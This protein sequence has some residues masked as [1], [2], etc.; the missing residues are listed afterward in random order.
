MGERFAVVGSGGWGTALGL[1]A[2]DCGND[3]ML[4]SVFPEEIERIKKSRENS[5]LKGVAI[6]DDIKL[7]SDFSD[8]ASADVCIVSVPSVAVR[9]VAKSLNGVVRKDAIIVSVGKGLEE[10]SLKRL[11]Q[12]IAEELPENPVVVLSGPS[13]AEEVGRKLPTTVVVASEKLEYAERI[14]SLMSNSN[15]RIYTNPDVLGVELCGTVKNVIALAAGICD[16]LGYGDNTKAALMTRGVHEIV[17]LGTALGGKNETFSGLSGI[18]DLI[19]TCTSMHSR[20]RRAGIL[21]GKGVPVD[22]AIKEIG[23]VEGYYAT[24]NIYELSKKM[25]VEMPI[26]EQCYNI[27]YRRGS[28]AEAVNR[29]MMRPYKPEYCTGWIN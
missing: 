27:L 10:K 16:G 19:V 5:L 26:T 24:N 7:S 15:F 13:H 4:W 20:N 29:L 8:L 9:S 2:F 1:T 17:R 18:G 3:V 14:Q 23:T 6:P 22:E 28:P 12:V 25:N 11:S 21:I